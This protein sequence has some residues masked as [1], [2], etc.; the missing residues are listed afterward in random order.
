MTTIRVFDPFGEIRR[1]WRGE[2]PL[3]R[4]FW[5]YGVLVGTAGGTA[6]L[7]SVRSGAAPSVTVGLVAV[8]LAYTAWVLVGVWRCAF[9]MS[10]RPFGVDRETL[11]WMARL[12]TFGWAINAVGVSLLVLQAVFLVR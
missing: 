6:I 1:Y 11:G 4:L 7:A 12:M 3:W 8:G 9:N 2:G 10:R 5:I